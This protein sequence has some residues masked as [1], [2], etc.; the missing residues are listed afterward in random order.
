VL[1]AACLAALAGAPRQLERASAQ[2]SAIRADVVRLPF[3][4]DDGAL[5]P[6]TFKRGYPL[7]TLVY[8]TLMWRDASG[9]P[10]PW[11]VRSLRKSDG[12]RQITLR[13]RDGVRW[14][15][16]RPLTA[17]DVA[18]TFDF[19]AARPHPRFTPQLLDV[20]QVRAVDP[21]TVAITLGEPAPGFADQPLA[22]LPILPRHIW[23]GLPEDRLAPSGL[24]VG[25]GPYRLVAHEPGR[26]YRFRANR[27]YFLGRPR[28]GRIEVPIVRDFDS[29]V[30]DLENRRI[31]MIPV[32]LP[33]ETVERLEG[34]AFKFAEGPLY[35]GTVLMFDTR[36]PPFDRVAARRAVARAL[37]LDRIAQAL[38]RESAVAADRGY[39]APDSP[40]ATTAPLHRFDEEAARRALRR[41]DLPRIRVLASESDPQR[42]EVGRQVVLALE[43]AG[44]QAELVELPRERLGA[45][46]GEN[47]STPRFEAAIWDTPPLASY[48]TDYLRVV[49]GSDPRRATLNYSG[50]RSESF[51]GLAA[52]AA[53]ELNPETRPRLVR[54]ELKLLADDLPV[55]PLVYPKAAFA[56]RPAIYDGWQFV[57]G[58]GILDK[59]SFLPRSGLPANRPLGQARAPT[60]PAGGLGPAGYVALGLLGVTLALAAA[61]LAGSARRRRRRHS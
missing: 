47:G 27:R 61:G 49:F 57:A 59:R 18:F 9:A 11:L 2:S 54:D 36:K 46:V 34:S 16:G 35:S 6:T 45:A 1:A 53:R 15:D 32:S 42:S 28:V 48:G 33:E 52:R 56:Y 12:G 20:Q 3:P 58:S 44:A 21:L 38:G 29:T 24:P 37:D 41:L 55:V 19:F 22:D 26:R 31:D 13:L 7:M 30:R 14:H 25:S 51:D 23:E 4:R 10:Q 17:S 5:T 43:R 60:N 39:V 50:Y 8:D 40:R